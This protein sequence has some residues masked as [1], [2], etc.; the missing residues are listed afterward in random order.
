MNSPTLPR[1]PLLAGVCSAAILLSNAPAQQTLRSYHAEIIA[2]AQ[3]D[4]WWYDIYD[5]EEPGPDLNEYVKDGIDPDDPTHLNAGGMP[6][7]NQVYVWGM[8][9]KDNYLW[10]GTGA[11]VAT[12]VSSTYLGNASP[13]LSRSRS[14]G[15][16]YQ[17]AEYGTSKLARNGVFDGAMQMGAPIE[18]NYGDWRPPDMFRYNLDTDEL[19]RLDL[20]LRTSH[21]DAW[22]LLWR[23][24]GLRSA[25][26][27]PSNF[28]FPDGLVIMAGPARPADPGEESEGIIMFAFDAGSGDFVGAQT[29]PQYNNIRKWKTFGE[30]AYTTV[31]TVNGAGE[32]IRWNKA[33]ATPANPLPFE[34]VGNLNAGGAELEVHDDGDGPRLY[35][36]TWPGFNTESLDSGL[37]GGISALFDLINAPA[38]L[39]RSPVIPAGGLSWWNAD[40]W[41]LVWTVAE[42]EPDWILAMTYGGGAMASFGGYL[43]WGTMHVPA[44]YWNA[45][46]AIYGTPQ[47]LVPRPDPY[48]TDPNDPARV[49]YEE[50]QDRL[51]DEGNEDLFNCYRAISLWRGRN[52]TT[53]SG[54]IE[55][56]YGREE[57]PVRIQRSALSGGD[58]RGDIS[59]QWLSFF[60]E[61][62]GNMRSVEDGE[63]V[64][65]GLLGFQTRTLQDGG[66][67]DTVPN[68]SGYVPVYGPEGIDGGFPFNWNNY[69][70]TMQVLDDKLYVGTMDWD[71]LSS[72][73][74]GDGANIYCFPSETQPAVTIS[75][76][77]MANWSSYGVRT[78]EADE[79]RGELYLGMANVQNLLY[80]EDY[81][82]G[83]ISGGWE[84]QRVKMRYPDDDFDELDDDWETT[85]FG[86]TG[87][88]DDPDGNED[89]DPTNNYDEWLAGTDADDP[90]SWYFSR[91]TESATPGLH[92]INWPSKAGRWYV[93]Y[94]SETLDGDWTR[95]AV[96][97][98]VDGTMTHTY[99][100][101]ASTKKFFRVEVV[102]D[103]PEDI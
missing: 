81:Y 60:L 66:D 101:S 71:D 103:P 65:Y 89:G 19:E 85:S 55:L 84:V 31:A 16:Y 52:F 21:P 57:M 27:T 97:E 1:G 75:G 74:P 94:E 35:V 95:V 87:V 25:G 86:S 61:Y 37:A 91:V 51:D 22:A 9:R 12:L 47:P 28:Y 43:Y 38:G 82:G 93:V 78:I 64:P 41:N 18:P 13:S 11:N 23:C 53:T 68:A 72:P 58:P 33:Y 14:R 20:D 29:F 69:T 70:W 96:Y 67:W 2:K 15:I 54:D 56:L 102:L 90:T 7:T 10:W 73:D 39:W 44:T 76:R 26:Y 80:K 50:D 3:P 32:V 59:S 24:L 99:D 62:A 83:S 63:Q 34:T 88:T 98:G 79:S 42:Y 40:S 6:K 4:E 77:G 49:A 92:D 17:V 45:H 36:N 100:P 30:Q 5:P 46:D 8:T 48:P